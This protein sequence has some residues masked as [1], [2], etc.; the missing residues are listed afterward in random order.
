[1]KEEVF[2]PGLD[3][4]RFGHA[5]V[6]KGFSRW[7]V[8]TGT[9]SPVWLRGGREKWALVLSQEWDMLWGAEL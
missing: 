3:S 4:G 2:D 9:R 5:E 7:R 1:M 6:E 8:P